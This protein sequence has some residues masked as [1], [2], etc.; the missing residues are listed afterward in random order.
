MIKTAFAFLFLISAQTAY[1]A[2]EIGDVLITL[3]PGAEWNVRSDK[4][5][6][7]EWLDKTQTKPTEDD[8]IQARNNCRLQES[9]R[10]TAKDSARYV[11]KTSTATA[12]QKVNALILIMDLDK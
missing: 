12:M 2:C 9:A 3:R 8:I 10:K 7:I 1:G 6:G 4:Y 11:L 5:D